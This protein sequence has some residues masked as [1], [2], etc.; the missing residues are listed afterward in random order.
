M[1]LLITGGTGSL[2]RFLV[3]TLL[4]KVGTGW[5]MRLA[6][7][8]V[9]YSRDEVKQALQQDRP[10]GRDPRLRYFLGDVRDTERLRRA[11][12]GVDTVI[13]TAALA[14][15]AE[16][17]YNPDEILKTNVLGTERVIEAAADRGVKKVVVICS[18]KGCH[19]A[20]FYGG[21]KF[22]AEQMAVQANAYTFP[23]GTA[24]SCVRFGNLLWSRDSVAERFTKQLEQGRLPF[25]VTDGRMSR[26][27]VTLPDACDF[28]LSTLEIM[29]GG[30][31]FVPRLK[32]F[33]IVDLAEA[34]YLRHRR[35]HEQTPLEITGNRPG[36]EKLA[37]MI[38][39]PEESTQTLWLEEHKRWVVEPHHRSW[40]RQAWEG[41]PVGEGFEYTS[42]KAPQSFTQAELRDTLTYIPR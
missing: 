11:M 20:N 38:L 6:E 29:R 5:A 42:D 39:T 23:R 15:V 13:H 18:D 12:V 41:E 4:A 27:G 21:S 3:E 37:E 28:I 8:I 25:R 9:I 40:S 2:G 30:E 31:V 19:A 14:R 35:T 1:N 17:C 33:R 7:R 32:S 36:G 34:I 24:V 10:H 16:G 22:L 26:F